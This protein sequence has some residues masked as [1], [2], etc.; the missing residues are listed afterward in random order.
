M[1]HPNII[2]LFGVCTEKPEIAI[3]MEMMHKGSLYRIL[4]EPTIQLDWPLRK[5]IVLDAAK[6]MHYLHSSNPIVMHR[7]FKSHNLL[8]DS[9]WR[10]K[11]LHF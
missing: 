4:H 3:L 11:V 10:V 7:D 2:Q 9:N 6:G 1:R 5:A 8:V